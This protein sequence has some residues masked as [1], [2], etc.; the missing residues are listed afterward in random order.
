MQPQLAPGLRSLLRRRGSFTT[1]LLSLHTRG[2]WFTHASLCTLREKQTTGQDLV[3]TRKK[4][5]TSGSIRFLQILGQ[6]HGGGNTQPGSTELGALLGCGQSET[7][8]TKGL[9]C[10]Q[11]EN[12]KLL[13][14]RPRSLPGPS[15]MLGN[16]FVCGSSICS[17]RPVCAHVR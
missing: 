13:S 5:S 15:Q 7:L 6:L 16:Y 9:C 14:A 2:A 1:H 4:K 8:H 10:G 12:W 17:V 3:M 11:W